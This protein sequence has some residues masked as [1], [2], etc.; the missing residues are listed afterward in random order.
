MAYES[1]YGGRQGISCVIVKRYDSLSDM[2]TEFRAG[3]STV[4]EV[5]YG[6]YVLIDTPNKNSEDNGKLFR[7]GM[8]LDNGFGGGEYI[9]QICGPDGKVGNV[10]INNYDPLAEHTGEQT[11]VEMTSGEELNAS[12]KY[13][14][15]NVKDSDGNITNYLIGFKFPYLVQKFV[16]TPVDAYYTEDLIVDITGSSVAERP[17]FR[18]QEIKIPKGVKGDS[19]SEIRIFPTIVPIGST[20]YKA[21]NPDGTPSG[22]SYILNNE[23]GYVKIDEYDFTKNMIAFTYSGGTGYFEAIRINDKCQLHY[24]CYLINYRASDQGEKTQIDIGPYRVISNITVS[25]EGK[26]IIK[27]T[28]SDDTHEKDYDTAQIK[29][30]K[31]IKINTGETEGTGDQI[32]YATY[33]VEGFNGEAADEVH[34]ISDYPIN[35]IMEMAITI[36]GD[37]QFPDDESHLL[38]QF[39]DPARRTSN[40]VYNNKVGQTDLG[41]VKGFKGGIS[42][43]G[44]VD[45]EEELYRDAEK[46]DPIKPE[47]F[48]T[49]CEGQCM[50]VAVSDEVEQIIYYFD[51]ARNRQIKLG[52][53]SEDILDPN[54]FIAI[55]AENLIPDTLRIN[56][57]QLNT[58]IRKSV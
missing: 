43:I 32:P 13:S 33:S 4:R 47:E 16:G 14:Q 58:K 27:Y 42:I 51:Y 24:G 2:I 6:E 54:L 39:S 34:P 41:N 55:S 9:G 35:Y 7:R 37:A 30:I 5:N 46:T 31:E 22:D 44:R 28:S 40:I 56:G 52:S 45:F 25:D 1:F 26:V 36:P 57:V 10:T 15:S 48:R 38:A 53:L 49:N 21:I 12:I 8:N 50:V 18:K 23:I 11:P 17:F 3:G 19:L 29:T 20:Y